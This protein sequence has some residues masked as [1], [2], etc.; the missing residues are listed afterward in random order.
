MSSLDAMQGFCDV[1]EP[2]Y[3]PTTPKVHGV[4]LGPRSPPHLICS[5]AGLQ[6]RHWYSLTTERFCPS[7]SWSNH[8]LVGKTK[9]SFCLG[10]LSAL[11]HRASEHRSEGSGE[12]DLMAVQWAETYPKVIPPAWP[13]SRVWT[14][15]E[16]QCQPAG[17]N[18]CS[19]PELSCCVAAYAFEQ[20]GC[21]LLY[22]EW[23]APPRSLQALHNKLQAD[24]HEQT[25]SI[26]I[27]SDT[28]EGKTQLSLVQV[29]AAWSGRARSCWGNETTHLQV[30]DGPPRK[31]QEMLLFHCHCGLNQNAHLSSSKP[32]SMLV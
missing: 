6:H 13:C 2:V 18:R 3:L 20:D 29:E 24:R 9:N 27:T 17:R 26:Y 28:F 12:L 22:F 14:W 31:P 23:T 25:V 19:Q 1:A 4:W 5:W 7:Q 15:Q 11:T 21:I 8:Q 10:C 30:P 32:Y 16:L